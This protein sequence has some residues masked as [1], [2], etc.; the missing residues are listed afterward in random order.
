MTNILA[1]VI[2]ITTTN[3]VSTTCPD[4]I[5]GC[6]VFHAEQQIQKQAY[7]DFEW[8]GVKYRIPFTPKHESLNR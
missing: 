8:N 6:A 5:V 4:K 3:M 1:T 7:L 2:F